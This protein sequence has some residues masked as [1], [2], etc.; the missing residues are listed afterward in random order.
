MYQFH[1]SLLS[2]MLNSYRTNYNLCDNNNNNNI[3]YSYLLHDCFYSMIP[4]LI[5][6]ET[7]KTIQRL[8]WISESIFDESCESEQSLDKEYRWNIYSL[9]YCGI[10]IYNCYRNY[11]KKIKNINL[12]LSLIILTIESDNSELLEYLFDKYFQS[13][14]LQSY[15]PSN[16][17]YLFYSTNYKVPSCQEYSFYLF[18]L[19]IL[20]Q[21]KQ[22]SVKKCHKLLLSFI[23]MKRYNFTLDYYIFEQLFNISFDTIFNSNHNSS[24]DE[25]LSWFLIMLLYNKQIK[26]SEYQSEEFLLT[27]Q[28]KL[29][30]KEK[31][32]LNQDKNNNNDKNNKNEIIYDFMFKDLL[33]NG[34]NLMIFEDEKFILYNYLFY[35][36]QM[37]PLPFQL[38]D[39]H[40]DNNNLFE[41]LFKCLINSEDFFS[42]LYKLLKLNKINSCCILIQIS[43]IEL[44]S[45][46]LYEH[47][48]K[49]IE[50]L[51]YEKDSD[52]IYLHYLKL[53]E[54]SVENNFE[55]VSFLCIIYFK[56]FYKFIPT[57]NLDAF[58]N[59]QMFYN[60]LS[61]IIS[62]N[63]NFL[64]NYE[65]V[66][67]KKKPFNMNK[68]QELLNKAI[69]NDYF[70]VNNTNYIESI[71]NNQFE[72]YFNNIDNN[73]YI[74][75]NKQQD[76]DDKEMIIETNFKE[77]K[78]ERVS[79]IQEIEVKEVK[80]ENN[81]QNDKNDNI[82]INSFQEIKNNYYKNSSYK[83]NEN[84]S[85]EG[86]KFITIKSKNGNKM[87]TF[88]ITQKK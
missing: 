62:G 64:L 87:K 46:N 24:S 55:Y 53:Y 48:N 18:C 5:T 32:Y 36:L 63:C 30:R 8:L 39:N 44:I 71:L 31:F 26:Q 59:K 85:N 14:C 86:K 72:N 68:F 75:N 65:I 20:I 56:Q 81:H 23:F 25:I 82:I 42:L 10:P 73:N 57:L 51:L 67:E 47:E 17:E 76:V 22:R 33:S 28:I 34:M 38:Q 6:I 41:R 54:I 19:F 61:F 50:R 66:S 9:Y 21:Q 52:S 27:K 49:S 13:S 4:E 15:K 29:K 74:D 16:D 69:L 35:N 80:E 11:Q 70:N 2:R 79:K 43:L 7:H 12:F 77:I 40:N 45:I 1:V 78:N 58:K 84:S 83:V 37:Y 88:L 3:N 60:L